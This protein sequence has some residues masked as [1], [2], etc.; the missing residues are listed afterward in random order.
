MCYKE[1]DNIEHSHSIR[2]TIKR[3]VKETEEL[4][5]EQKHLKNEQ[6]EPG[7][8]T[9]KSEYLF[10]QETIKDENS[11]GKK[12]AMPTYFRNKLWTD[13]EREQLWL[14]KLNKQTRYVRGEKIDVS[15]MEGE[16]EY[17][18]ALKYR[19]DENVALGYPA[20]PWSLKKYK[21]SRKKFGL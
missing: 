14:Q 19:Q 11:R 8:K 1:K 21:K 13:E 6:G 20:E 9:E 16:R 18:Q 7:N 12:L 10:M 15:T 5:D 3:I 2:Y 4:M 17:D